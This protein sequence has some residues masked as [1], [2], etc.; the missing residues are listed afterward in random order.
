MV[1]SKMIDDQSLELIFKYFTLQYASRVDNKENL[2]KLHLV[3]QVMPCQK[4]AHH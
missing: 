1:H 4:R 2:H 3:V